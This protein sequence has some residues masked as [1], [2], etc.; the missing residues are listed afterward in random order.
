MV[1]NPTVLFWLWWLKETRI[2]FKGLCL[3]SDFLLSATLSI[4]WMILVSLL[5]SLFQCHH[6]QCDSR[7]YNKQPLIGFSAVAHGL[8]PFS[9]YMHDSR[10]AFVSMGVTVQFVFAFFFCPPVI[11]PSHR[12]TSSLTSPSTSRSLRSPPLPPLPAVLAQ[13]PPRS[14][15]GPCLFGGW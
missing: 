15:P 6:K 1:A 13:S 9:G 12:S 14:Q 7:L 2:D 11:N 4:F 3:I 10:G 8:C 5:F